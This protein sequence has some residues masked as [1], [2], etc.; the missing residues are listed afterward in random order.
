MMR[1]PRPV[2]RLGRIVAAIL[3]FGVEGGWIYYVILGAYAAVIAAAIWLLT[4][5]GWLPI[6]GGF[7]VLLDG[8]TALLFLLHRWLNRR[9]EV[10]SQTPE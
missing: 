9:S 7:V 4:R 1:D 3:W 6:V 2:R 8:M 10:R 5:H